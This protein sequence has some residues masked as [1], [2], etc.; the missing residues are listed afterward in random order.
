MKED[1]K[2]NAP[3]Y[4]GGLDKRSIENTLFPEVKFIFK[5]PTLSALNIPPNS[6]R[7]ITKGLINHRPRKMRG[8]QMGASCCRQL[9]A[10]QNTDH[11][12]SQ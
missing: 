3:P 11:N 5:E 10:S 8:S 1:H 9:R 4:R 2:S 7:R 6:V 12:R